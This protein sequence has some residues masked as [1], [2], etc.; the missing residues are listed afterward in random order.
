MIAA[1]EEVRQQPTESGTN[2]ATEHRGKPGAEQRRQVSKLW[3]NCS[4]T[5]ASTHGAG[6]R[7]G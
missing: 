4:G 1:R 2:G 3:R 5:Q 7:C 6:V